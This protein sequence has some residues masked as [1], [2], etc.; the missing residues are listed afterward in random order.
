MHGGLSV[1]TAD[2]EASFP[3]RLVSVCMSGYVEDL[4][5]HGPA[6]LEGS[7]AIEGDLALAKSLD[8]DEIAKALDPLNRQRTAATFIFT[9]IVGCTIP[10]LVIHVSLR[11]NVG[12]HRLY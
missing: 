10:T 8:R 2:L 11:G 12:L 5:S 9:S 1:H 4:I 7:I 3:V 6:A